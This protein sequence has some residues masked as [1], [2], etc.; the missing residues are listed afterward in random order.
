[1]TEP[2]EFYDLRNAG[3]SRQGGGQ[4]RTLADVQHRYSRRLYSETTREDRKR[5]RVVILGSGW[6]GY[7][8][9]RKLSTKEFSPLVIS[10]RSYFLFTPLLTSTA[11]GSLDF[12]QV[13]EPIRDSKARV[14][15]IQAQA[16]SVDFNRKIVSCEPAVINSDIPPAA[17]QTHDEEVQHVKKSDTSNI[18]ESPK[19]FRRG[20]TFDVP[21]DKLVIAVGAM[22]RTFDTPGV[23]ENALFFKDIE[24]ARRVKRR[25]RECFE[26]AMLPTTSPDMKKWLLHF[27]IV[28]AGPTGTELAASIRDLIFPDLMKRYPDLSGI[29]RISLYDVAP[30]V[31]SMFDEHLSQYA[32]ETMKSEGIEIKT[33][34][35]VESLRW[36][37]PGEKPPHD[38]T[39][40][41]R[42]LTIKTKEQGE[43]GIGVCVWATGNMMDQFI[44]RS[45]D[46]VE[47]FPASSVLTHGGP[48][49]GGG[50]W[51]VKKTEKIGSLAV[52][53]HLQVQL[54][55]ETGRTVVL[56][57]VFAI[58]DN[59]TPESN[60]PPATAQ[61]TYQE[62][63]WLGSQL[64]KGLSEDSPPFSFRSLG[65]MAYI[66]DSRA[67]M[68]FPNKD[69]KWKAWLPTNVTGRVARLIW[70]SAYIT[71]SIS[72]KN[73][74]RVAIRW[75]LNWVFG[76]DVSR[77]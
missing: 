76:K 40:P 61:A 16:R 38:I 36:G 51:K 49:V 18:T 64:N 77:Y 13:I 75:M 5:E 10:P 9:S 23:R 55:N 22:T 47:E 30:K 68:Q 46:A 2:K 3:R 29:P 43:E 53:D 54:V 44:T 48:A 63:K 35:H 71:M 28:G 26:L 7:T 39:D 73:K 32:M 25:V 8:L 24:D 6:G 33:S 11:G 21:Y 69:S 57:D 72:W 17:A 14:G 45:L 15:Y 65:V 56:K 20:P 60:P 42:C 74:F 67:L 70:N 59:A 41:S 66:G 19:R 31:L 62:A 27:A 52:N 4:S 1:M 12:S 34:H 50:S 58:G 37:A